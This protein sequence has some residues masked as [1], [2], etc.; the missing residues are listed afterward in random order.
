MYKSLS[1]RNPQERMKDEDFVLKLSLMLFNVIVASK[2][3]NNSAVSLLLFF[4]RLLVHT[5]SLSSE[6][7]VQRARENTS[8]EYQN[9]TKII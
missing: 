9:K 1:V 7:I 3:D 2:S 8:F 6:I 4:K 5:F